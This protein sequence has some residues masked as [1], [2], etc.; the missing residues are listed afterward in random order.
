VPTDA[1][2]LVYDFSTRLA[3]N[4]VIWVN[5]IELLAALDSSGSASLSLYMVPDGAQ[6]F[7]TSGLFLPDLVI[8]PG[9]TPTATELPMGA[10]VPTA[11]PQ[12]PTPT[13]EAA[14]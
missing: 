13:T 12:A 11:T 14:P 4:K 9:P 3:Q 2:V 10:P 5:A 7:D 8:T 1:Q 6:A